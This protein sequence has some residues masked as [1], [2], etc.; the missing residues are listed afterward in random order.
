M[1]ERTLPMLEFDAAD[2]PVVGGLV[3]THSATT[4]DGGGEVEPRVASLSPAPPVV[5]CRELSSASEVVPGGESGAGGLYLF[6]SYPGAG[7][8]S[9]VD[10]GRP[11]GRPS[12]SGGHGSFSYCGG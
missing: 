7:D 6:S 3:R 8:A 10:D 5:A 1:F 11:W 12:G 4:L 2:S 9:D